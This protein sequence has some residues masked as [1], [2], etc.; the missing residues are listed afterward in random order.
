MMAAPVEQFLKTLNRNQ[1]RWCSWK[2]N[3]HLHAGLCG[4]T[5]LDLLFDPTQKTEIFKALDDCGYIFFETPAHRRYPDIF[6]A[7]A[8]DP[9]SGKLIHVHGHFAMV[10]GE[11]HLKSYTLPWADTLLGHRYIQ[12]TLDGIDLY[13]TDPVD[14]MILLILR[15]SLK[16]RWRDQIF[17][18][19]SDGAIREFEWLK[20]RIATDDFSARST[21][22]LGPSCVGHIAAMAGGVWNLHELV[23]LQPVFQNTLLKYRRMSAA[24]AFVMAKWREGMFIGTTIQ[25]R[26]NIPWPLIGRMRTLPGKGLI[27]A[28][29]GIDGSG[30]SSIVST[31]HNQWRSKIDIERLYFGTGDGQKSLL[32]TALLLGRRLLKKKKSATNETGGGSTN[33]DGWPMILWALAC[34]LHK[35]TTLRQAMTL[36]RRGVIVLCDRFPQNEIIGMNDGPILSHLLE[37]PN[38]NRRLAARFEA[39]IFAGLQKLAYADLVLKLQPSL[40]IAMARKPGQANTALLEEKRKA[41][42]AITYPSAEIV[43]IIDANKPF[44]NVLL[45]C[46][47]TI[48]NLLKNTSPQ[49]VECIGLPGAGKTTTI[50]SM[51]A[52]SGTPIARSADLTALWKN[53][54]MLEKSE[55]FGRGFILEAPLWIAIIRFLKETEIW[56]SLAALKIILKMPF[57]RQWIKQVLRTNAL[58]LDQWLVQSLWSALLNADALDVDSHTLAPLIRAIYRDLPVSFMAHTLPPQEAA[59]RIATRTHGNSRFDGQNIAVIEPRLADTADL[60]ESLARACKE[61]GFPVETL[62]AAAPVHDKIRIIRKAL[63]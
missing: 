52:D 49:L 22:L 39:W 43:R 38:K 63:K 47:N 23:R 42:E 28:V 2:S 53:L 21:E 16:R 55:I 29:I 5:D 45:D 31:L 60:M 33:H 12:E 30:K 15:E 6:D 54:P 3:E 44:D 48:W 20:A 58:W 27:V 59:Q 26:L 46:K 50:D 32:Q 14:E 41:F 61:A 18:N 34:G 56:R 17:R 25:S 1:I 7:I 40:D 4:N 8:M 24:R 36:N 37:S 35:R 9:Q 13:A 62:D 51:V 10:V 57:Q 19:T 11:K